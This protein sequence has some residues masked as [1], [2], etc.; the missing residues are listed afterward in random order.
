M[1]LTD[2]DASFLYAE[3]ASAPMHGAS[4]AVVEGEID[5][6]A[7]KAH[8]AS[9]LHLIPRYRQ[10]LAFVPFNIAHP[11][12]VEDP[13][14]DLDHHVRH[15]ALPAGSTLEDAIEAGMKLNEALLSRERPLWKFYLIS[16]VPELTVLFCL[17]HHAMVD[18]ASGIDISLVL[19]DLQASPKPLPPPEKPWQPAAMPSPMELATEAARETADR[20]AGQAQQRGNTSERAELL[21][22][23]AESMTRFLSEPVL[24]APWNR[25]MVGPRRLFAW[26]K[27]SFASF[28]DIR[29]VFGGT[30]NDV[31]LALVTEAAAR[32]LVAHNERTEG[33]HLRIMVPVSVRR[34][35]EHGALGNR[36]SGIFPVFDAKSLTAVE[37][38][39]KVRWE[40]EH[41][42]QQRE[43]QAMELMMETMPAFPPVT[44]AP[45][46]LVGTPMDPTALAA[47]FPLPVPPEFAPRLPMVGYNF[48]CTNVPGVQTTQY[49]LGHP[50]R[51]T[52]AV[53]MLSGNVGY[54]VAVVSYNQ[55][56]YFNLVSDPRVM[57]DIEGMA[58]GIVQVFEEL[59]S[60]AKVADAEDAAA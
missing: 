35:D 31:V 17:G 16:G 59:Y 45:T 38:L 4:I 7:F 57:P 47:R 34:E 51:D 46:L 9:R 11:K 32:Y 26:R 37:R 14:F 27:L 5:F 44:M 23:A 13:A 43:A 25:A 33:Q 39:K 2:H 50:I 56:L 12:W 10:R 40:T 18:G 28:R 21:R 29:R 8:I 19:F 24:T 15:H 53:L 48:T 55:N 52:L 49:L 6:D 36:V 22:R 60:A 41:I 54:G 3:T 42:K 1:R 20:W 58:D 30:V